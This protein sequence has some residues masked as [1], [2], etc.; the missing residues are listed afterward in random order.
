MLYK[1]GSSFVAC[2]L[3]FRQGDNG[4]LTEY[5]ADPQSRIYDD[6]QKKIE[7]CIEELTLWWDKG[8]MIEETCIT[9][10]AVSV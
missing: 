10:S 6:D 2:L 9:T 4:A 3:Q 5:P 1:N 7:R 8:L